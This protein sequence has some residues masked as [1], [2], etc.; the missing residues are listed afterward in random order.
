MLICGCVWCM[1]GGRREVGSQ[2]ELKMKINAASFIQ[3]EGYN[4]PTERL[5]TM[6]IFL[7]LVGCDDI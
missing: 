1:A 6:A 5:P 2:S 3:L 4:I 7:C